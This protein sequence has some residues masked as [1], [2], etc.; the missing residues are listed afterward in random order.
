MFCSGSENEGTVGVPELNRTR[1]FS[2]LVG[3]VVPGSLGRNGG[4]R[5][6]RQLP[7]VQLRKAAADRW[8]DQC[9]K[10]H[11]NIAA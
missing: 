7:P 11:A 10:A 1:N 3:C 5:R 9:R 4:M 6:S 8:T 2:R